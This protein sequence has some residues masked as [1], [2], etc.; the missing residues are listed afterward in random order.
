M[1]LRNTRFIK[2]GVSDYIRGIHFN[3]A[4]LTMDDTTVESIAPLDASNGPRPPFLK[5]E[6]DDGSPKDS[7]SEESSVEEKEEKKRKR[8]DLV[9]PWKMVS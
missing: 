5:E 3:G 1:A 6:H 7:R 9:P 4:W 2:R 8:G